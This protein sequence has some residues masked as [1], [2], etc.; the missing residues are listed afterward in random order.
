MLQ[1][2]STRSRVWQGLTAGAPW[3]GLLWGWLTGSGL[4]GRTVSNVV[5]ASAFTVPSE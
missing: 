2:A 1:P 4:L 3:A 5:R